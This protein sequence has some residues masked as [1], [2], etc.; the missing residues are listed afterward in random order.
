MYFYYDEKDGKKTVAVVTDELKANLGTNYVVDDMPKEGKG[1]LCLDEN[2]KP[3][4]DN[5]PRT[6]AEKIEAELEE[7]VLASAISQAE[8]FEKIEQ[9][10][11]NTAKTMAE[12]YELI[13]KGGEF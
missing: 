3:Y 11:I 6:D 5:T 10:R 13:A 2:N 4:Y 1:N 8:M 7:S 12:I 9:N